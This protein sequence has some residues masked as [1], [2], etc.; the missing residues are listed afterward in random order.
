MN[1]LRNEG[2]NYYLDIMSLKGFKVKAQGEALGIGI[3][4]IIKP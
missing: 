1:S 3:K 2:R 4:R